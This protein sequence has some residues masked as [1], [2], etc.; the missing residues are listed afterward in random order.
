[1][2]KQQSDLRIAQA[3]HIGRQALFMRALTE[4]AELAQGRRLDLADQ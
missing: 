4:D 3:K 2:T 1:M